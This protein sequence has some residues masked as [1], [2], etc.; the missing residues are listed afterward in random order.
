MTEDEEREILDSY[1]K[2][3]AFWE[4]HFH[5]EINDEHECEHQLK[6]Y[7][8]RTMHVYELE[9]GAG[10]WFLF[11][12]RLATLHDVE[13]GEA[14]KMAEVLSASMLRINYCPFCGESLYAS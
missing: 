6:D 8:A 9:D 5:V 10:G 13:L 14:Y 1:Y 3:L 11:S 4:E 7:S 2:P 12:A